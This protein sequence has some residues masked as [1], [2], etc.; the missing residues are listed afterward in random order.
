MRW[1]VRVETGHFEL[2]LLDWTADYG[3]QERSEGLEGDT[4]RKVA[5][6]WKELYD[7]VPVPPA[8]GD[9]RPHL[10]GASPCLHMLR[11]WRDSQSGYSQQGTRSSSISSIWNDR[12]LNFW[13]NEREW[14][15]QSSKRDTT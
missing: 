1:R 9:R 5:S 10:V 15:A 12:Q 13:L 6:T 14:E 2:F 7:E 4:K 3:W 8:Q 11:R